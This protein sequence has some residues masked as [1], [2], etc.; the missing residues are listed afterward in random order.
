[1]YILTYLPSYLIIV[2]VVTVVTV[3]TVLKV[4][5]V[6]TVGTK[7]LIQLKKEFSKKIIFGLISKTQIAIKL[8]N[9]NCDET[10]KKT[11]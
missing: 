10:R 4:V 7:K 2:I 5:T 6:V 11:N 3:V 9:S 8:K 1:M